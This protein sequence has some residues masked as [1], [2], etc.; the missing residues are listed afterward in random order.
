MKMIL[1]LTLV[2]FFAV[3]ATIPASGGTIYIVKNVG[4]N[5]K[6]KKHRGVSW[7]PL[8]RLD[9]IGILDSIEVQPAEEIAF[10]NAGD[11]RQYKV[12]GVRKF[13]VCDVVN[14]ERKKRKKGV[15]ESVIAAGFANTDREIRRPAATNRGSD[16]FDPTVI[17][18]YNSI[19]T[20]QSVAKTG[21]WAKRE[22]GDDSFSFT[23]G[24][25]GAETVYAELYAM[26]DDGRVERIEL[27]D[28]ANLPIP[29]GATIELP[30]EFAEIPNV[31]Y[32]FVASSKFFDP[33]SLALLL[34]GGKPVAGAKDSIPDIT[35]GF[36]E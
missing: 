28:D 25:K 15:I 31:K 16:D 22:I 20:G 29:A 23:V 1:K 8:N 13:R 10:F 14:S 32:L 2:L 27:M 4:K 6:M 21:A 26:G 30:Y 7:A 19:L 35:F 24:N 18:I 17:A 36:V 12:N 11:H 5:A 33:N 34:K 9:K 3:T